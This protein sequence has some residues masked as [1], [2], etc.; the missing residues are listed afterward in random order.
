M[1]IAKELS[2]P[3]V[4][5]RVSTGAQVTRHTYVKTGDKKYR[6]QPSKR[7]GL[8]PRAGIRIKPPAGN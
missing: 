2:I 4:R 3:Y 1:F 7:L 8:G 5:W 6:R